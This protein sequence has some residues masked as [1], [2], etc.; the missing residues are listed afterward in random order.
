MQ[1]QK[2]PSALK[3]RRWDDLQRLSKQGIIK[4]TIAMPI[5]GYFILFNESLQQHLELSELYVFQ[6]DAWTA[7]RLY[8]LYF[9]LVFIAAASL[10]F[11]LR[12]P[13]VV[14]AHGPIYEFK[15]KEGPTSGEY[16]RRTITEAILTRQFESPLQEYGLTVQQALDN[17]SSVDQDKL[18][19]DVLVIEPAGHNQEPWSPSP[20]ETLRRDYLRL[21]AIFQNLARQR[22]YYK[23]HT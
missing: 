2:I 11:Q 4:L 18:I 15:D 22:E 7:L 13:S 8:A 5:V 3:P 14:K 19:R 12:C 10:L 9:G 21:S 6:S 16:R 20:P 23:E 17:L 1:W